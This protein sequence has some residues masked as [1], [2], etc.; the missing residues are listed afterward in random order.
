MTQ[1]NSYEVILLVITSV[2][3]SLLVLAGCQDE[4]VKSYVEQIEDKEIIE[5]ID[6]L[7][8]DARSIYS[9]FDRVSRLEIDESEIED[10]SELKKTIDKLMEKQTDLLATVQNLDIAD[11]KVVELN[12]YLIESLEKNLEAANYFYVIA[13]TMVELKMIEENPP[14][15]GLEEKLNSIIITVFEADES[16]RQYKSES[17]EALEN[18]KSSLEEERN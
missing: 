2:F 15:D 18:W 3:F 12:N 5:K 13:D 6:E 1:K 17:E 8:G 11:E 7:E 10:F 4:P 14:D 16:F 9:E